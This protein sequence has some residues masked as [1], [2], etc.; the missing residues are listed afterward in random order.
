MFPIYSS[1]DLRDSNFKVAP[2]DANLFPAGFNNICDTDKEWAEELF[3]KYLETY[4]PKFGSKILLL[5]EEHT[6]NAYYWDNVASLVDM[7]EGAGAKVAVAMPRS[8]DGPLKV[9]TASGREVLVHS[10]VRREGEV[11]IGGDFRADLIVSNNDFSREYPDFMQGLETPMNPPYELGW[12]RR[13]KHHFFSVYNEQALEFAKMIDLDPWLLQV[14]TQ[15][16]VDFDVSS[17]ASRER[18]AKEVDDFLFLL[19]RDLKER[20]ID[21]PAF[22]FIKNNAGTYGLGVT[23]VGSGEEV[24]QWTYKAR[25]KMKASKGGGGF[26]DVIIQE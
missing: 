18:L 15:H 13:K 6:K 2:V 12:Y 19:R 16:F 20:S 26:N 7:M 9:P 17:E 5:T 11:W 4:Y 24:L 8:F 14:R 25:K 22:V 10:S 23:R 3:K 21:Q 1:F